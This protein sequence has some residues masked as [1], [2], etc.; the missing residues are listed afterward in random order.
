MS[1]GA[2]QVAAL[3]AGKRQTIETSAL[4]YFTWIMPAENGKPGNDDGSDT[5][6]I[7][8]LQAFVMQLRDLLG[9]IVE[10]GRF[11]PPEQRQGVRDA[12]LHASTDLD[13]LAGGLDPRNEQRIRTALESHWLTGDSLR[14]K[15]RAWRSRLFQFG[16]RMNRHWLRSVLRWGNTILGSLV[17]ALTVGAAGKEF[18]DAIE[19][20]LSDASDRRLSAAAGHL[21]AYAG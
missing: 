6:D 20:F 11:I 7:R 15:L 2:S 8:D 9:A 17:D 16:R 10:D 4:V 12:W 21:R 13:N 3:I 5:T 18:K 14:M 19:N 1:G